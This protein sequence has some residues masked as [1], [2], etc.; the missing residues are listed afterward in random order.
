VFTKAIEHFDFTYRSNGKSVFS[1]LIHFDLLQGVIL[2]V[3]LSFVYLTESAFTNAN[4]FLEA[5]G[6]EQFEVL[7]GLMLN[8]ANVN[9]TLREAWL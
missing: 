2:I 1:A 8:L 6:L 7:E 3:D 4:F 5:S 9:D